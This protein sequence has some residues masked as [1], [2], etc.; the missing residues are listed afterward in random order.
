ME[1]KRCNQNCCVVSPPEGLGSLP[2]LERG[3]INPAITAGQCA[4]M[5]EMRFSELQEE[6]PVR[7][8]ESHS[9]ATN[10]SSL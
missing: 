10:T 6:R 5:F 3:A 2:L 9:E 1:V 8:L 7:E 4:A